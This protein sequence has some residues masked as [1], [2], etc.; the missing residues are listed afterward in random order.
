M[1]T[2]ITAGVA[3][4]LAALLCAACDPAPQL[5]RRP[6]RGPQVRATVVTIRTTVQ[7]DGRPLQH[8]VVIARGV[9]RSTA[10]HDVWRLFDTAEGRVT[11]VDDVERTVRTEPLAAFSRRRRSASASAPAPFIPRVTVMR[12]GRRRTIHGVTAE[13]V[14]IAAGAYRRELWVAKHR[15]I[16]A[17][18]FAMMLV[19]EP[20]SSPLAAMARRADEAIASMRGFP[21]VDHTEVPLGDSK[22]V[23]DRSV[24]SIVEREVPAALLQVPKGYRDLGAEQGGKAKGSK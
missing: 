2:R 14:V 10:E 4:A 9:A 6:S 24:V 17:E 16:P 3:C 20:A 13:E 18:L 23:I 5:A 12:S 1:T 22:M 11:V 15:G 7:P 8:S 19:S 21:L